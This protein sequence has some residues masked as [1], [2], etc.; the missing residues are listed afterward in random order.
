MRVVLALVRSEAVSL[1]GNFSADLAPRA[2]P[3]RLKAAALRAARTS[4]RSATAWRAASSWTWTATP[5]RA[6]PPPPSP[7][8]SARRWVALAAATNANGHGATEQGIKDAFEAL[9]SPEERAHRLRQD[10]W[11]FAQLPR[12]RGRAA[13]QRRGARV[14]VPVPRAGARTRTLAALGRFLADFRAVSYRLC[15]TGT[16][17]PSIASRRCSPSCPGLRRPG[18]RQRLAEDLRLFGKVLESTFRAVSRRALLRE[19]AFERAEAEALR[20]RYLPPPA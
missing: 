17:S 13:Q 16:S 1:A 18:M 7:S 9:V 2:G 15:A 8:S 12:H 19:R 11:V 4:P 3:K 6:T 10:L 14:Q 20:D 5:R